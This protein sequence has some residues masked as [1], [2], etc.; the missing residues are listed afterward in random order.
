MTSKP[1]ISCII[2]F[3]NAGDK[4]FIEAIQS[5]FAQTYEN[6]ELLLVDDGSTDG[7]TDI[8]ISY[9][10]K[11]PEKVFYLEH[12]GHQNRGMSATRNLGKRCITPGLKP[13]LQAN[14]PGKMNDD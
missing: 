14:Q 6:W 10:Q 13:L 5:V 4:F 7:S 3:F 11:Y 8:A 1:L 2:I 12:E 9:T